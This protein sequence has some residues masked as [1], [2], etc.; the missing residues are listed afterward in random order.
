MIK[1]P[2]DQK[3]KDHLIKLYTYISRNRQGITNQVKLKDKE[4]E[5]SGAIESN[6]RKAISARFKKRGMSWSIPGALS[7]LKIKET[8]LNKEW[9][10]WWEGGRKQDLKVGKFNPPL[11]ASYFKED[12]ESLPLIEVSIPALVGPD[13]DK[14]WVDV[15]CEL[16]RVGYFN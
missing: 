3:E 7:L 12:T 13:Q 10:L 1:E 15:L 16:T 2:D 4:I 9:N 8:I 14:P 6:V 5:R 11:S